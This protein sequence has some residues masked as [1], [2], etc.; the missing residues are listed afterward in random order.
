VKADA[1]AQ[2]GAIRSEAARIT[3][4]AAASRLAE[5]TQPD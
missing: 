4:E 1:A 2:E 5:L 3:T